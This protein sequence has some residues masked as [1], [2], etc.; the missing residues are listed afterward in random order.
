[1]LVGAIAASLATQGL[2]AASGVGPWV[3]KACETKSIIIVDIAKERSAAQSGHEAE[4]NDAYLSIVAAQGIVNQSS[5]DKVYLV[6][7]PA[8]FESGGAWSA[9]PIDKWALEDG[10]LPVPSKSVALDTAKPWPALSYLVDHYRTKIN[11]A[12][13]IPELHPRLTPTERAQIAAAVT[14]AGV[15]DALP[16]TPRVLQQLTSEGINLK[17]VE[18]VRSLPT[19]VAAFLW[20]KSRFLD[21]TNRKAPAVLNNTDVSFGRENI[22]YL[23]ATKTFCHTLSGYD[24][25]YYVSDLMRAYKPASPVLGQTEYHPELKAYT[26]LGYCYIIFMG[27]NFSVHSGFTVP[28][29]KFPTVRRPRALPID[30]NGAYISFYVTDGDSYWI[31][32]HAHWLQQRVFAAEFG[33]SPIG[34]SLSTT[35]YD[36]FPM[37]CA[38]RA[39]QVGSMDG[40]YEIIANPY[41]GIFPEGAEAKAEFCAHF[42]NYIDKTNHL[43]D[44]LNTFGWWTDPQVS[45]SGASFSLLGYGGHAGGNDVLWFPINGGDASAQV[46]TGTTQDG[47]NADEMYDALKRSVDKAEATKPV[48]ATICAGTGAVGFKAGVVTPGSNNTSAWAK[49]VMDRAVTAKYGGRNYYFALP[50]DI[51]ATWRNRNVWTTGAK[52]TASSAREGCPPENAFDGEGDLSWSP[53]P[54]SENNA[55]IGVDLGSPRQIDEII[56]DWGKAYPSRAVVSV[57]DEQ[58]RTVKVAS[59]NVTGGLQEIPIVPVSARK[60]LVTCQADAGKRYDLRQLKALHVDRDYL[61]KAILTAQD[62]MS[63]RVVGTSPG[64][65]T[66]LELDSYRKLID[67]AL[68]VS[69]SESTTQ[70][71]VDLVTEQVARGVRSIGEAAIADPTKV[72]K[73]AKNL[74]ALVANSKWNV[75]PLPTQ[76]NKDAALA[77]VACASD[78]Q[79]GIGASSGIIT[80]AEAKA[81]SERL[82]W[83]TAAFLTS[84]Q[85]DI[86][87]ASKQ[88][89]AKGKPVTASGT[90]PGFEASRLTDGLGSKTWKSVDKSSIVTLCVDL[91]D[92]HNIGLIEMR[93]PI[94]WA[95]DFVIEGSVDNTTWKTLYATKDGVGG[96]APLL[97][98]HAPARYLKFTL[99]KT[100]W[101]E[102][103]L[104]QIVVLEDPGQ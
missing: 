57:V 98:D 4:V 81:Y 19:P 28:Q 96:N 70:R 99:N 8:G 61:T 56:L 100:A 30:P 52:A 24:H 55:W 11:G 6:N 46:F 72:L 25:Y 34:W 44:T 85:D 42:R 23:I 20:E 18:D 82:E 51:G 58:G 76:F 37:L 43:F 2:A 12:I 73:T 67:E 22:D 29:S 94:S 87:P 59:V 66:K 101:G 80:K 95:K 97:L 9:P 74:D 33:Q 102:F 3:P 50:K 86:D 16:V 78:V 54:G 79:K 63:K 38:R 40:R 104:S 7:G 62:S 47:C 5:G 45:Q 53:A 36:V 65:N 10:L 26:H 31:N 35:A 69:R 49:S 83:A 88:N 93:Q 92:V 64:N 48:F 60:V 32:G 21:K 13:L 41:D 90:A 103:I 17:V 27:S 68:A 77:A 15:T 1:M 71:K 89:I 84:R 14:M 75:G 39:R 91:K